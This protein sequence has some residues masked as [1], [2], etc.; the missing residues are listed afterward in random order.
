MTV[1]IGDIVRITARLVL[2]GSFDVVNVFHFVVAVQ[3]AVNDSA[4]MEEVADQF[5]VLYTKINT[6]VTNRVSYV[7]V[8]GQNITQDVLLP[9]KAWPIL[10][11]GIASDSMLPE[12]VSACV[13]HRTLTPRVRA[14]KFLPPMTQ[15]SN[16]GGTIISGTLSNITDFGNLLTLSL[17]TLLIELTYVAFNRLLGTTTPVTQAIA[18]VR[19]RTQR[20]RRV[21]VG[22]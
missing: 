6:E 13:F 8:E 22:S 5:D 10:V 11:A 7:A 17:Q 14:A 4:F 12:T 2:D 20:R 15:G 16:V 9:S 21:G 1:A 18:P 19:W 3:D